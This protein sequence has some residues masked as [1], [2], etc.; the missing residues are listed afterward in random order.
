MPLGWSRRAGAVDEPIRQSPK[1]LVDAQ[2]EVRALVV[3]TNRGES[4]GSG[5][6]ERRAWPGPKGGGQ[7]RRGATGRERGETDADE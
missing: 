1:R 4:R 3:A 5:T 2:R 7:V 6:Q